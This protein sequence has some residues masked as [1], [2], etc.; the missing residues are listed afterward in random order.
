LWLFLIYK[1]CPGWG[2]NLRYVSLFSF[3]LSLYP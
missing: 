1:V 3:I 2:V